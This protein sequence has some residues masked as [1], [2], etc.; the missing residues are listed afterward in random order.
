MN[1]KSILF[2]MFLVLGLVLMACEA[3]PT[4]GELDGTAFPGEQIEPG[5]DM[6]P[7]ATAAPGMEGDLEETEP[8]DELGD[9]GLGEEM[10]EGEPEAGAVEAG[11]NQVVMQNTT[12]EPGE[13]T[14]PVG[15]IVTWRN[16]DIVPHTVTA[17]TR[18]NPTGE[19][20]SGILNEG[21]TFEY[22]FDQPG[23]YEYFCE[24]HE[25]MNGTIIVQE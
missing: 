10:G 25:G 5:E 18:D 15:T 11:E 19:F 20:E 7:G 6:E 14:V 17:G 2:A 12:F 4:E 22:T 21:Q 16:E 23:T 8:G 13:I 1:G 9:E 3:E 24:I